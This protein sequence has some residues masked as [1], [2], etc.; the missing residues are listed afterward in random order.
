[1]YVSEVTKFASVVGRFFVVYR[2]YGLDKSLNVCYY[3]DS[4]T[5]YE[6]K[7]IGTETKINNLTNVTGEINASDISQVR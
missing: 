4:S 7:R 3:G 5:K 2:A 6:S 1:M